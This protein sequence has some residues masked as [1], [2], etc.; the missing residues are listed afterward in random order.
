[1][2]ELE[3]RIR[4]AL[5]ADEIGWDDLHQPTLR[6][7][8]RSPRRWPA[9]LATAAAVAVVATVA[10]VIA[11]TRTGST[12]GPAGTHPAY[13]GYAW[14]LTAV[15]DRH[16]YVDVAS[17]PAQIAFSDT[18][19]SGTLAGASIFGHYAPTSDGYAVTDIGLAGTEGILP[20]RS[21]LR[22]STAFASVFASTGTGRQVDPSH[23]ASV[24]AQVTG[25]HL[26]LQA[27]GVALRLSRVG[28]SGL[29]PVI[30]AVGYTWRVTALRDRHGRLTIPGRLVAD[31]SFD[32]S[33]EVVANDL[34][35]PIS[36]RFGLSGTGYI[37]SDTATGASGSAD[38]A[39]PTVVRVRAAVDAMVASNVQV[40]AT[41]DGNTLTLQRNGITLTLQRG[42]PEPAA[43]FTAGGSATATSAPSI[44]ST[45]EAVTGPGNSVT[46]TP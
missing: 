29:S 32:R 27:N 38:T 3:T 10:A 23:P 41:L 44:E 42:H 28:P 20:D 39:S 26:V 19:V 11:V 8:H 46:G 37:V 14:Q 12:N 35:A 34:V 17:V 7:G 18:A 45:T 2:S 31:V 43:Q 33:G 15:T 30:D 25:N 36:G 21:E 24:A 5:H 22:I 16:G 13:A 1:M 9:M 6:A 4:D 40:T